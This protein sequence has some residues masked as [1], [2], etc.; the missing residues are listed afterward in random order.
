MKNQNILFIMTDQQR[1]DSMGCYGSTFC[2]TPTL[3]RLA[4]QGTKFDNCY[5]TNQI[6]TPSR[7]SI[8]SGRHLS[9]HGVYRVHDILPS[10]V[11]MFP[12][13]LQQMGYQTALF[14]KL[15]V[16]ARVFEKENR[17]Q[18]D[19]FEI[20]EYAMN[21]H[22]T[23]GTFNSYGDWLK[24]NHPDFFDKLKADSRNV[25]NIPSE[26][27]FTGWAAERTIDFLKNR[28]DERPFFCMMSIVA[29]HDPYSCYPTDFDYKLNIDEI[30]KPL[31]CS[32]AKRP[33]DEIRESEHCYLGNCRDYNDQQLQKIRHGY[34]SE[35]EF[36]DSKIGEVLD[37]LKVAGLE[38]T[39]TVIFLSDHGDMLA[40][41][42]LLI[43][44]GFG[45]DECTRVP[46]I[47]K[48]PGGTQG[49][50]VTGLVQPT[51]VAA[52]VLQLCG[53]PE[54]EQPILAPDSIN[55]LP[56]LK[57][58]QSDRIRENVFCLYRNSGI[59]DKKVYFDPPINSTMI[60]NERYKLT[61]YH[62]SDSS[63][64]NPGGT[65]FDMEKDPRELTNLYDLPEHA[66]TKSALLCKMVDW[67]SEMQLKYGGAQAESLIP[68]KSQ[69]FNLNA[70]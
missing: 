60:R 55:L 15:H 44:G 46:F 18:N 26:C 42:E 2:H 27:H 19:G 47:I 58:A 40:D 51:D 16:S 49:T 37:A 28:T 29:P 10:S 67:M 1:T 43:K 35:V 31:P 7:A 63:V 21:P 54:E 52:T 30:P 66:Q 65:L 62:N 59:S 12:Y 13:K 70:I 6:C 4:Q 61:Y 68:D 25:G 57:G 64:E 38:D 24:E 22:Q 48:T 14:G 69:T 3:D 9:G 17:N 45:Y 5:I 8:M 41:R 23:D 20:Y 36:L 34:Y 39:T 11:T 32:S 56:Y 33:L 53:L 50:T